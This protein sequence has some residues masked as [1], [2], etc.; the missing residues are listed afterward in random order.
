MKT[1]V[2]L[3]PEGAV[4]SSEPSGSEWRPKY[5]RYLPEGEV[6]VPNTSYYRR[7]IAKGHLTIVPSRLPTVVDKKATKKPVNMTEKRE[8]E[9]GD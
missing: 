3:V 2:V 8:E 1:L 7:L 6:Q 9:N 5:A 4:I